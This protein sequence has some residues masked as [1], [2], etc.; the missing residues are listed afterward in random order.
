M[1]LRSVGAVFANVGIWI[2]KIDCHWENAIFDC[3]S[4][5]KMENFG[6]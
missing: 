5:G 3:W 1:N 6:G 2:W 4:T